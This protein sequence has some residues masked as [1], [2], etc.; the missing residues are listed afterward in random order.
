MAL[1]IALI[2]LVIGT[3]A[4]HVASP[5]WFTPIASNWGTMDDTV[6]LTFWVTGAVFVAVNLFMAYTIVRYRHRKGREQRA[7]YEPEYR[8]LE[9]WL[10]ILT[11]VG[12][13]AMLA[14]GLIVWAKFVTVPEEAKEVEVIGQQWTWS[15][16]LPGEDGVLGATD[17]SFITVANPF[18]LDARDEKG[19]DDV[20]VS[21]PELHLLLNQPVKVLL[22]SKDVLHNF[23][24]A[25]FRVKMDLVP[26]MVTYMW[27]TPTRTGAFDVLCEELCGVGHFA[28]RGRVVVDEAAEY[29][30]WL[31]QQ[32]TFAQIAARP[33]PDVTA[34]RATFA[35]CVACHGEHGEGNETLNA[36]K[37]AGQHGWYLAQQLRNFRQSI[38]GGAPGETIAAQMVPFASML[39][40]AAI[41]NV[42]AYIATLPDD[43]PR[44]TLQGDAARGQSLYVT[45]ANCHGT[46]GQGVW[47]TKA[48]RLANQS[49]WY[50]MR[51]M[52][53]FKMGVRGRHPQDFY[54]QQMARLGRALGDDQATAD[55]VAYIGSLRGGTAQV[56][57]RS[58]SG[59][60]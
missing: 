18:G 9:W 24:V 48:P 15:Y 46:E 41:E 26:G 23:T 16:R 13:A 45:C 10:T 52:K 11:S 28:M 36:P 58:E 51:Q 56:A 32:P 37:L 34:G 59:E 50:L 14:P 39:D 53:N 30:A 7:E 12:V 29:Q 47:S 5:W 20:L 6:N 19:R 54:G 1:A 35:T 57:G 21:N 25:E 49:D 22:R 3:I 17:A 44:A 4:F 40:D 43:P 55:L 31:A 8:R 33:A 38:R 42:V 60:H 2:L 27:L